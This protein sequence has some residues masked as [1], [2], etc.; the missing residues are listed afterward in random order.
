MMRV[1]FLFMLSVILLQACSPRIAPD[2][3]WS[4]KRWILVELKEVPVQLSDSR[5]DAYLEFNDGEKRFAGNGGCNHISGNY[6]LDGKELSFGE[7]ISTKMACPDLAFETTFLETLK[8]VDR[9]E[10]EDDDLVLKDGRRV[11]MKFR[12]RSNL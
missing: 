11:V 10:M 12:S 8:D 7:V 3:Y 4:G 6:T 2:Q 5:R 1:F 9:F